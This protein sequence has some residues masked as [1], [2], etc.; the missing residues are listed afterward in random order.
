MGK[1]LKALL[2]AGVLVALLIAPVVL[3]VSVDPEQRVQ[4]YL[5]LVGT[6]ASWPVVALILVFLL[7]KAILGTLEKLSERLSKAEVAGM[8]F[9]LAAINEEAVKTHNLVLASDGPDDAADDVV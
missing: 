4:L 5:S 9:E 1:G 7:R 2:I 6:I 3:S 8:I